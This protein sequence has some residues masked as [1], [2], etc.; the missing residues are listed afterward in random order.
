MVKIITD[1]TACLP[2]AVQQTYQIPV[3]PQM[4]HFGDQSFTEGQD[5]DN[6]TFLNLLK[7]SAVLP[8]TAA[9]PPDLFISTFQHLSTENETILCIHPSADLS[10]T[11]RSAEIAKL[12]YPD[13]DIHIIDTRL[14]ASPLGR[15]VHQAAIWAKEDLDVSTLI[16]KIISLSRRGRIY[17]LVGSLEF[18]ARGGRIGGASKL[19]GNALQIKPILTLADGLVVPYQKE[20]TFNRALKQVKAMVINE[21][22]R[23][24]DGL[25][26]IMHSDSADLA[27][28][29]SDYF[30]T[31]IP[32]AN[33]LVSSLPPAI[34][35]H[36]EPGSIA[37]GFF[38]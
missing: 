26:T 24:Q 5:I 32:A 31:E 27:Q 7:S 22:P 4:I 29:L 6:H 15:V 21:F 37:V 9:P 34:I 3:I 18:L 10:G 33:P 35:T 14:I 13:S 25:L 36:V 23:D 20:R 28:E 12:E 2:V 8:K 38:A 17:F 1:T 11:V 19:L 16:D 30:K